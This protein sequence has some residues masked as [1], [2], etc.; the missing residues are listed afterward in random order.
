MS[1]RDTAPTNLILDA[2]K[3]VLIAVIAMSGVVNVLALTGSLYMLQIYDRVLTSHS[4][5][6][7]LAF[8]V[9]AAGLYFFQGLLDVLRSQILVRLGIRLDRKLVPLAHDAAL[10]LPLMGRS[11]NDAQ[12]PVRDVE[13]VRSFLSSQGPIAIF[14]LPWMP[15]YLV[16]VYALHFWL[17]VAATVGVVVLIA[18]T[19]L[20]EYLSRDLNMKATELGLARSRIADTNARN[21]E[22]LHA[23]GFGQRLAEK[24]AVAN[25]RYLQVQA[26]A[27]DVIGSISG[28]S[29]VFRMLLQ[30]IVLGLGAYL[31]L[32]GEVTA[33]AIIAASIATSRALAPIELAISHWKNFI[34]AR[35][36]YHRLGETLKRLPQTAE[37]MTLP[38]PT[39]LLQLEDVFVVVPGTQKA[40]L[41]GANFQ[42]EAGDGLGVIGPSASGKSSMARGITGVWPTARGAIRLDG[43]ALDRWP[44]AFFTQHIGYLPQ[45]VS[46]MDGTIAENISRFDEAA[47]SQTI[48]R[49][50]QAANVHELILRLPDGYETELGTAGTALSAGQRQRIALARA[51]YG[52]PFLVVLDEPNSNLDNEGDAALTGAIHGIRERGGIV[53]V[54]AHRPSALHAVNK[55][56][57]VRGGQIEKFGARDEVLRDVLQRPRT[58]ASAS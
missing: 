11:A 24:F 18:L 58:A 10:K 23:M 47:D 7:L 56:A 33:G 53:I 43:A 16:F 51:L 13:T 57:F 46:L 45:D 41:R 36:A 32:Q 40:T 39:K 14:D 44:K 12:R 5:P 34:G 25:T 31:T 2:F 4:I 1:K 28:V 27:S 9:L 52:D 20:T 26:R 29:R 49:A 8:S 37:P 21:A 55:V 6:T 48:I 42:L 30:S 22:V 19:L 38:A 3:G 54:I 17:G 50:A 15:L 35:Q